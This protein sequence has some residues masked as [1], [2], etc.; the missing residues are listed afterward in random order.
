[1]TPEKKQGNSLAP[2]VTGKLAPFRFTDARVV[3]TGAASGMGEQMAHQL[4][5]QGARLV[6]VD[7]DEERLTAVAAVITDARPG[8]DVTTHVVD[9][10]DDAA[11]AAFVEELAGTSVDLLINNAGVALGGGFDQVTEE[12][13]DWVLQINLR[14]PIA[15]ARGVLPLMSEGA[16]IVNL[17]S[18]FG[19]TGPAG[20][21]A[22]STSKFGLRGFSDSLRRELAPQGIGVTTVHPGGIRTRIAETA[23]ITEKATEEQVTEGKKAFARMLSY[24]A[25]KA[26]AEI[27]DGVGHRRARVLIAPETTIID[28]AARLAPVRNLELVSALQSTVGKVARKLRRS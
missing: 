5:D 27:L 24:P 15:L 10:S 8:S 9:L 28:I 4:A 22:Y 1:M 14:A 2:K 25:D 11:I 18:L 13:F 20:Q 19:L 7:R 3:L 23:R 26:A 12:E 21:T 16:H 17:S 6:L